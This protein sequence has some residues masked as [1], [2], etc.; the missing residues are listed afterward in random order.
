MRFV[1]DA[2]AIRSG[3]VITDEHEWFA[4]AS[5]IEELR[6]GKVARD[7]GLLTELTLKVHSPDRIWIEKVKAAAGST[8]D[9]F[10]IS[11]TDIDILALAMEL[12]ATIITDDY[13]IQNCARTLNV[14]FQTGV[15]DGIKEVFHWTY[16]CRGCGRTFDKEHEDC[17]ICGSDIRVVR[18]K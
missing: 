2:T 5:V 9:I 10:R 3:M 4:P 14:P 16:R 15:L 13:S 8:G 12:N 11:K 6:L 17:P 1:L 7:V 18:K